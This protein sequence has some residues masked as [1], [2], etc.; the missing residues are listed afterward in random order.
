MTKFLEK[1]SLPGIPVKGVFIL[2]TEA[3]HNGRRLKIH[4]PGGKQVLEEID[5]DLFHLVLY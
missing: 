3:D 4:C 2:S 5:L 1:G